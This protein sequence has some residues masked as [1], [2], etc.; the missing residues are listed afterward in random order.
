MSDENNKKL[1]TDT[2]PVLAD[3]EKSEM[4]K[5]IEKIQENIKKRRGGLPVDFDEKAFM[6]EGWER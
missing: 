1:E 6:D 5:G 2:S 4:R 3:N